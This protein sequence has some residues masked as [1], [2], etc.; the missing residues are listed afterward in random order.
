[1]DSILRLVIETLILVRYSIFKSEESFIP[2]LFNGRS[3]PECIPRQY[4]SN[5]ESDTRANGMVLPGV[6][7][8]GKPNTKRIDPQ[9]YYQTQWRMAAP[10]IYDASFLKFRELRL[11]YKFPHNTSQYLSLNDLSLSF[12]GRNLAILAADLP[13]LDPQVVTGAG[14]RQGLENAQAPS[15]RSFGIN[16]VATF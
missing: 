15:T 7:E 16:L 2:L 13:Y 5:G 8:N 14:N 3:T 12:F 10:N 11:S 1:M 4:P 9:N 6:L